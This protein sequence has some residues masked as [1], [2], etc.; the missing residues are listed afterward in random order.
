[1]TGIWPS[2]QKIVASL[3]LCV[4]AFVSVTSLT[5]PGCSKI[6][7]PSAKRILLANSNGDGATSCDRDGCSCCGFQIVAPPF[8]TSLALTESASTLYFSVPLRLIAPVFSF[9][10]P[11][12]F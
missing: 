6:E 4:L 11:P 5:C 3:L 9:Y 8:G 10:H 7:W 2:S 12:R 1:M